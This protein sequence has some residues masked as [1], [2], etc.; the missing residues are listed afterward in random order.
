MKHISLSYGWVD[1]VATLKI[2]VV[3]GKRRGKYESITFPLE[4]IRTNRSYQIF[5]DFSTY[6]LEGPPDR[7]SWSEKIFEGPRERAEVL[8]WDFR[9]RREKEM[10]PYNDISSQRAEERGPEFQKLW[11]EARS[12]RS[13][14]LEEGLPTLP[15]NAFVLEDTGEVLKNGQHRWKIKAGQDETPNLLLFV[16]GEGPVNGT[17][18]VAEESTATILRKARAAGGAMVGLEVAALLEPGEKLVIVRM[19]NRLRG[20]GKKISTYSWDGKE[21]QQSQFQE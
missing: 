17:I 19:G 8:A 2:E 13:V 18:F 20:G 7:R 16:G 11:K 14:R 12:F 10:E 9:K 5:A 21:L 15:E 4:G 3:Y 1:N 6:L